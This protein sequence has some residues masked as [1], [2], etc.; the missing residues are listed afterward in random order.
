[1]RDTLAPEDID[2]WI[3]WSQENPEMANFCQILLATLRLGFS[4]VCHAWGA[5]ISP[6]MFDPIRSTK[7]DA[8]EVTPER[9][10]QMIP[11]LLGGGGIRRNA[12]RS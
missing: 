4:A 5:K 8:F 1:M 9:G 6:E 10:A 7:D 11:A 2:G 3:A 12:S